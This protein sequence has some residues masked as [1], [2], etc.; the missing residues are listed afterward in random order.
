MVGRKYHRGTFKTNKSRAGLVRV[1][2]VF[3]KYHCVACVPAWCIPYHVTGS[4]KWP[5]VHQEMENVWGKE[6]EWT[7]WPCSDSRAEPYFWRYTE[8]TQLTLENSL[9]CSSPPFYFSL[10]IS[11]SHMELSE[12]SHYTIFLSRPKTLTLLA[13]VRYH[14]W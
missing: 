11:R 5:I 10:Q 8:L 3:W 9:F 2:S 1:P 4:C 6:R 14:I 12:D 7:V 13:R